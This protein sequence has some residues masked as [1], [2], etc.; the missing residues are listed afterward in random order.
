MVV[1]N[2]HISF[3]WSESECNRQELE[4]TKEHR[5]KVLGDALNLIRFPL[6]NIEEFAQGPAQSGILTDREVVELFLYFS[7]NPKPRVSAMNKFNLL[8]ELVIFRKR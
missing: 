2:S 5:R 4:P 6:M 1:I 3:R 8:A 7:L